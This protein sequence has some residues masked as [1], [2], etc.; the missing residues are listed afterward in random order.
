MNQVKVE[1]NLKLEFDV[2][3]KVED[4]L[5][6]EFEEPVKIESSDDET[7]EEIRRLKL[8]VSALKEKH[9]RYVLQT[10][11]ELCQKDL[12]IQKLEDELKEARKSKGRQ[13]KN[14]PDLRTK[15]N[16]LKNRRLKDYRFPFWK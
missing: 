16:G 14:P 4:V 1:D 12:H 15:I 11:A 2:P 13:M 5:K 10:E 9:T 3:I 6:V 7:Q 8:E